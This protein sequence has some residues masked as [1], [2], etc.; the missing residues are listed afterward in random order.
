MKAFLIKS[1]ILAICLIAIE[2]LLTNT[3]FAGS[4]IPHFELIVL[5]FYT[6]TN[7]IHY[8]L[9]KIISTNIRQFNPW[10]LGI[11]MSKMFLYIFF[12]IGYLWFHREHAKV[13]LICL[14]ITYICFTVIEI[15]SIT[16]IV[17][18]KKS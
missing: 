13:F 1:G 5:F 14:I 15:T 9:V 17:N 8:K 2:Y 11:N 10:F 7:L 6:V 3:I 16:K 12:A 18:Q 4:G